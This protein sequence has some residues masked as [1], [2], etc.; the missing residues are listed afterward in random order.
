MVDGRAPLEQQRPQQHHQGHGGIGHHRPEKRP[1]GE[2]GDGEEVQVLRV[3]DGSGHAAQVGGNG[4]QHHQPQHPLLLADHA[5][6]Q[7]GEG[8]EGEQGHIIG[9]EH[10]AEEAQ[11]HQH[12]REAP[13]SA[14]PPQQGAAQQLEHPQGPEPRHNDH[15]TEQQGQR[16]VVR[17]GQIFPVRRDH[18]HRRQCQHRR[19]AEHRLPP[20]ERHD[21]SHHL[22]A[23]SCRTGRHGLRTVRQAGQFQII[24]P[25]PEK[26]KTGSLQKTRFFSQRPVCESPCAERGGSAAFPVIPQERGRARPRSAPPRRGK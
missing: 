4:L 5:E 18:R 8:H 21:L 10:A 12:H 14:G 16:P 22:R 19:R 20:H 17:I 13:R 23:P 3:A 15:Q 25:G 7:Q 11:Q 2:P 26:N 9:D 6:Y 24:P 1:G